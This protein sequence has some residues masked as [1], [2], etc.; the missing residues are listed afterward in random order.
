MHHRT[1]LNKDNTNFLIKSSDSDKRKNRIPIG[2][3]NAVI[4]NIDAAVEIIKNSIGSSGSI[5]SP[6]LFQIGEDDCLYHVIDLKGTG[7]QRFRRI[8]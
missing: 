4:D 7:F 2:N 3:E 1:A 8:L 6:L 5:D